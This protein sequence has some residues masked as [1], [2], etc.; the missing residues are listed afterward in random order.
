M[1]A[2]LNRLDD[3][4]VDLHVFGGLGLYDLNAGTKY[5]RLTDTGAGF[6]P[7]AF[8]FI[9]RRDAAGCFRHDWSHAYRLAAQRGIELLL[10]AREI[11]V[12]IDEES[13][14]RSGHERII[15]PKGQTG[16]LKTVHKNTFKT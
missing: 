10:N 9:A 16:Q 12:A 7:E 5:P 1:D 14:E 15:A 3:L 6:H 13:G 4:V 11:R 2:V 8:G